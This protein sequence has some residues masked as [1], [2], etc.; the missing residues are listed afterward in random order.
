MNILSSQAQIH[1]LVCYARYIEK[2]PSYKT[3]IHIHAHAQTH[4]HTHT[5]A[6]GEPRL[7]LTLTLTL[8]CESGLHQ[9]RYRLNHTDARTHDRK[10]RVSGKTPVNASTNLDNL[11]DLG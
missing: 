10:G 1:L 11:S 6:R 5:D 3:H 7:G 8:R 2:G 9:V 4:T